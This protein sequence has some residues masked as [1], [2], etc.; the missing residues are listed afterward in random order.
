MSSSIQLSKDPWLD[1]PQPILHVLIFLKKVEAKL[2]FKSEQTFFVIFVHT[3]HRLFHPYSD[4]V[5]S[6]NL[7]VV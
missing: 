1:F 2:N 6:G 5:E 3:Q 4:E 7:Q